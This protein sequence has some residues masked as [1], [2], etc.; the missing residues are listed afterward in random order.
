MKNT[1]AVKLANIRNISFGLGFFGVFALDSPYPTDPLNY[2][3]VI[4]VACCF[5]VMFISAV[6][7]EKR[8][9]E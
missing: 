6:A 8:E 7:H 9:E 1:T 5:L 4:F 3:A 2:H